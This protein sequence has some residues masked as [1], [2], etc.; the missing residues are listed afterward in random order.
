MRGVREM[1]VR[2]RHNDKELV[3]LIG[4]YFDMYRFS[5]KMLVIGVGLEPLE[6]GCEKLQDI[7]M[8]LCD[9]PADHIENNDLFDSKSFCRDGFRELFYCDEMGDGTF[10]EPLTPEEILKTIRGELMGGYNEN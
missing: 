7:I 10:A 3:A 4:V 5:L 2:I 9:I 8:D 6:L 1:E